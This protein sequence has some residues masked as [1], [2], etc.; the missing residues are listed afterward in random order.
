MLSLATASDAV[1]DIA[2]PNNYTEVRPCILP[3]ASPKIPLRDFNLPSVEDVFKI[4]FDRLENVHK[5]VNN[6]IVQDS[7]CNNVSWAAFHASNCSEGNYQPC[8]SS[9]LPLFRHNANSAAMIK[10]AMLVVRDAVHLISPDQIPVVTFD[11]PLYALAKQIQWHCPENFGEDKFVVL[12][13]GLHIEMAA[14]RLL[15]HWLVGSGWVQMLT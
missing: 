5:C 1:S 12:L 7:D 14:L 13:G 8:V 4:E 11:Q 10:H 6:D 2:L 15:G 3:T 9:I